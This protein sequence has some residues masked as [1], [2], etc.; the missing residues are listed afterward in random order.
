MRSIKKQE[1]IVDEANRCRE[2]VAE[3]AKAKLAEWDILCC[4]EQKLFEVCRVEN[5]LLS[6]MKEKQN[7]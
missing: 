7:E 2:R 1:E 5:K 6:E 4:E 3:A